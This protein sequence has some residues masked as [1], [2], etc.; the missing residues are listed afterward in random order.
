MSLLQ[1]FLGGGIIGLAAGVTLLGAGEIMGCSGIVSTVIKNPLK[2]LEDPSQQWKLAFLSSFLLSAYVVFLPYANRGRIAAVASTTSPLA[3]ALSGLLVGFGT[4]LGNGCTSGHGICGLPR[5]SKR[6]LTA[7]LSFMGAAVAS[8]MLI[9]PDQPTGA[10]FEFLRVSADAAPVA[11]LSS[12]IISSLVSLFVASTLYGAW[13]SRGKIPAEESR[14]RLPAA[15]GGILAAA[16]FT[17]SSMV[18]PEAVRSFLDLSGIFKGTWDATLMMVMMGGLLTS[19]IAYQFVPGFDVVKSCPKLE[20]PL[21]GGKYGVPTNKII[22][23]QLVLGS[24]IFGTGWG[25][26]G[27]CPG[28]A[29]LL[30]LTGLSGMVL[31]YW[32]AYYIGSRM[33]ETAKKYL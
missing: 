32:P 21:S 16:G 8:T 1:G 20:K 14:K 4:K 26:T 12:N 17:M 19:F 24:L 29:L 2:A 22:D 10:Y 5:F 15:L 13:R 27:A 28:P 6:S 23:R 11:Y 30:S 3:Y 31:Q 7:V 25:L 18:Y 33:G 9:S